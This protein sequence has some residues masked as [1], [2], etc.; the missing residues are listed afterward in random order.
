M[1]ESL[2]LAHLAFAVVVAAFLGSIPVAYL[3][4][5]VHGVNVFE[6]GTRQAGATNVFRE[7]GPRSGVVVFAADA[8]KGGLAILIA[9]WA[10]LSGSWLLLPAFAAV[11]GHWNSP[12]TRFRGGDGVSTALGVGVVIAPLAVLIPIVV[13]VLVTGALL[14]VSSHPT[15]WG[16][17]AGYTAF[18]GMSMLERINI[19]PVTVL[20][21]TAIGVSILLHSAFYHRRH[22]GPPEGAALKDR[23]LSEA[24]NQR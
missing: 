2:T 24:P 21:L 10:G 23:E 14:T 17:L 15:L 16:G 5:R 12:M 11:M 19:G 3:V 7:V 1:N 4:A 22:L 8:F 9:N 13:G 18:L 20:G 6:T